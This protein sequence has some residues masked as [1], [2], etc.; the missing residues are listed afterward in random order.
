MLEQREHGGLTLGRKLQTRERSRD[1]FRRGCLEIEQ[2][3]QRV[4]QFDIRK[5][6]QDRAVEPSV[7]QPWQDC[8]LQQGLPPV[9]IEVEDR[10]RELREHD[11]R[12]PRVQR[13]EERGH[14]AVLP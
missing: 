14:L 2:Q 7:E 3:A 1:H 9:G 8:L 5:I 12:Q 4:S 13:A 6:L 11:A 10:T